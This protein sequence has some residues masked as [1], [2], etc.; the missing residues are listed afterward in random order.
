MDSVK[1]VCDNFDSIPDYVKKD[2]LLFGESR[3]N[4]NENKVFLEATIS[5]MKSSGRFSG[6]L[7]E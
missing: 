6:F 4:E 1:L 5:Y 7:F 2:L 3:L